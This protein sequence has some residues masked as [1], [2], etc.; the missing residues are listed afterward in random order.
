MESIAAGAARGR[1]P[2]PTAGAVDVRTS[3]SPAVE[4]WCL[5]GFSGNGGGTWRAVVRK[6]PFHI[7]RRMSS[8]LVLSARGVSSRQ[9]SLFLGNDRLWLRDLGSTNGTFVNG[10][11]ITSDRPLSIGDVI[12]FA[13]QGCRLL[14]CTGPEPLRTTQTMSLAGVDLD[15]QLFARQ[16]RLRRML[17]EQRLK[18]AFQPVLRLADGTIVGYELL[19]RGEGES[20]SSL[21]GCGVRRMR[22]CQGRDAQ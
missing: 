13:D 12:H 19:G 16:R 4:A 21:G 3:C 7:G 5:E 10:E 22:F 2:R 18:A 20:G 9:A 11:R 8:D 14:S 17:R 1:R 15:A 6:V